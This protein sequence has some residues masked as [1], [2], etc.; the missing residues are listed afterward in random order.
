MSITEGNLLRGGVPSRD[1][2]TSIISY[3]LTRDPCPASG[4]EVRPPPPLHKVPSPL[5]VRAD[6]AKTAGKVSG[7]VC[8]CCIT[9]ITL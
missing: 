5:H 4:G 8:M 7:L 1:S 3:V 6:S 2:V 9:N